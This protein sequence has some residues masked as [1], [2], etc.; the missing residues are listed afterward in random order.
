VADVPHLRSGRVTR[1][2]LDTVAEL[3][4]TAEAQQQT[5]VAVLGS[6][7]TLD[8]V[9]MVTALAAH[10]DVDLFDPTFDLTPLTDLCRSIEVGH[11]VPVAIEGGWQFQTRDVA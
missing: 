3:L 7:T 10:A 11:I 2:H 6:V 8:D 9:E 5:L 4:E 1:A